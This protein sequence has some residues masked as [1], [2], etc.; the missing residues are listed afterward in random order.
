MDEEA[1]KEVAFL[2]RDYQAWKRSAGNYRCRRC[3]MV[4][5]YTAEE[6]KCHFC[7]QELFEM[8]RL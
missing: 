4:D 7:G 8:D 2:R 3:L 6:K 1:I 5:G